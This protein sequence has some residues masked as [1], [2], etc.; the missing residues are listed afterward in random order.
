MPPVVAIVGRPNVGKSTLFNRITRSR[1]AIVDDL[2]G[3]TRDRNYAVASHDDVPFL[4]VDTGGFSENDPDPFVTQIHQQV[5]MAVEEADAVL[6]LLDGKSGLSPF[7]KD[8]LA[9]LRK[10]RKTI[11]YLVNKVDSPEREHVVADF[12]GLGVEPLFPVSAEHG[13]GVD[14]ALDY[15]VKRLPRQEEAEAAGEAVRIAVVGRP[16]AGKSSLVNRIL[17]VDRLVVSDTPGTTRDS[18][19]TLCTVGGKNY[20]LVDTAGLRKKGRAKD[21]VERY[22]VVRAMKAITDCDVALIL[23]DPTEG[24]TDQDLHIAGYAFDR[25]CACIVAANKWDLMTGGDPAVRAFEKELRFRAGFLSFAPFTTLS[26]KTGR[27]VNRLFKV[28]DEVYAQYTA[29][30]GTGELNRIFESAVRRHEPPLLHGRQ[31]KFFYATQAAVKPP[32]FICFVNYPD[33]VHF[34][35]RRFLINHIRETAGLGKTP[36]HLIFRKRERREGKGRP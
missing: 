1:K 24:I 13:R 23:L 33:A 15:L 11:L 28:V 35:Y 30:I 16:N 5:R 26:A 27:N 3:V 10:S 17:G 36:V 7:D 18:V 32:T 19:D 12:A 21:A 31:I 2:P 6:M 20:I 29:K 4:L 14:E 8:M 25:H 9:V 22:S 34:S